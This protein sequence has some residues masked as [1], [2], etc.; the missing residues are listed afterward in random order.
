[1]CGFLFIIIVSLFK[2]NTKCDFAFIII[3]SLSVALA[4]GHRNGNKLFNN[5]VINYLS[6]LTFPFYLIHAKLIYRFQAIFP[7]YNAITIIGFLAGVLVGAI[8]VDFIVKFVIKVTREKIKPL[9]IQAQ[10]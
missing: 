2:G 1:M 3:M 7:E 9:F 10:S 8:I 5:K 6:G 4:F